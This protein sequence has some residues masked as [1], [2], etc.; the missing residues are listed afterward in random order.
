M[1]STAISY[2]QSARERSETRAPTSRIPATAAMLTS[3]LVGAALR[4]N[5]DTVAVVATLVLVIRAI[6]TLAV[7]RRAGKIRPAS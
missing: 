1:T 3:L 4:G 2:D 5:A 6:K 7:R